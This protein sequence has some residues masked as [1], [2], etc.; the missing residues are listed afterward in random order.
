MLLERHGWCVIFR[1]DIFYGSMY[2]I[3][4]EVLK[5]PSIIQIPSKDEFTV[6]LILMLFITRQAKIEQGEAC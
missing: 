6:G 1:K 4:T 5:M 2:L 3:K